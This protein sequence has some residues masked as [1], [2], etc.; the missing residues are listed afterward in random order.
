MR[1]YFTL[2]FALALFSLYAQAPNDSIS[3]RYENF[4]NYRKA[5]SSVQYNYIDSIYTFKFNGK[6]QYTEYT[7]SSKHNDK[8]E[9]EIFKNLYKFRVGGRLK[10][11]F[12]STD[13][14]SAP[15]YSDFEIVPQGGYRSD[16]F[17]IFGGLG[18]INKHNEDRSSEGA[19]YFLNTDYYEQDDNYHFR[20]I[21]LGVEGDDLDSLPNYDGY[22]N[23]NYGEVL[24]DKYLNMILGGGYKLKQ[25]HY[26][27]TDNQDNLVKK[28]E[29]MITAD[30]LYTPTKS[31]RNTTSTFFS[32]T[33]K[34][35]SVYSKKTN[36]N[37]I[38]KYGFTN[39]IRYVNKNLISNFSLGY[40]STNEDFYIL[41][42][43]TGENIEEYTDF[44]FNMD[45]ENT[46]YKGDFTYSLF[47][48][49][50]KYSYESLTDDDLK[51]RDIQQVGVTPAVK[52][53][54]R[55]WY[56]RQAAIL[57]YYRLVNISSARS[58]GNYKDYTIN[59]ITNG[60]FDIISNLDEKI[61]IN[62]KSFYRKFDHDRTFSKSFVIKTFSVAD[63]LSYRVT[64]TFSAKK[65][66]KFISEERGR[67]DF[68]EFLEDPENIKYH[69]YNS[70]LLNYSEYNKFS[71]EAEYFY[72]EIDTYE[73]EEDNY[74]KKDLK[75]VYIAHGPK[76]NS[77][78][79]VDK[80]DVE[81]SVK[82]QMF[83]KDETK[84]DF[85]ITAVYLL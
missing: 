11:N 34:E 15:Q 48:K 32:K 59:S 22:V 68:D 56:V 84:L 3:F 47:S 72:Y 19:K 55:G 10:G 25:Y 79:K 21:D 14:I 85:Y 28:N 4:D 83:R 78:F 45:T 6:A 42:G 51:D 77:R 49:Y 36:E 33:E 65:I 69:Y 81:V 1:K 18:F 5:E 67:L 12:I 41:T 76:F 24:S 27:N 46:L 40:K 44:T 17:G 9:A 73:F 31:V 38:S 53:D 37:N 66:S 64:D 23:F 35:G 75:S 30:F 39:K 20:Q 61:E 52:Y 70:F 57:D 13:L 26:V 43:S 58:G 63:T 71:V 82:Y 7:N 80:V 2:I 54:G 62:L 74:K 29:Y 8:V 60:G 16:N 50:M